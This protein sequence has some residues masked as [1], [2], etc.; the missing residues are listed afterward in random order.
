M[1]LRTQGAAITDK[2]GRRKRL[3]LGSFILACLLAIVAAL[4]ANCKHNLFQVIAFAQV[5]SE[6]VGE[7]GNN[8][9][10]GA[11]ASI[12]FIFLFGLAYSFTYTPLQALYCAEY[13]YPHFS[14]AILCSSRE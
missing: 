12:T 2:I 13:A 11:N 14:Q 10:N 3:Y 4:T 7:V 6:S 1:I 9:L 8:N 5:I